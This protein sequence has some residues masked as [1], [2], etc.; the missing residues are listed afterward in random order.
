MQARSQAL[1]DH[2][3]RLKVTFTVISTETGTPFS[4]VG[5]YRHVRTAS[6]AAASRSGTD[7][8][9]RTPLTRPCSSMSASSSDFAF[10]LRAD[11]KRWIDG[12]G[13]H[14]SFRCADRAANLERLAIDWRVGRRR[15]LDL[16]LS[17]SRRIRHA[18]ADARWSFQCARRRDLRDGRHLRRKLRRRLCWRTAS[19]ECPRALQR[20]RAWCGRRYRHHPPTIGKEGCRRRHRDVRGER[21][22]EVGDGRDSV[23]C[24]GRRKQNPATTRA[25]RR[26]VRTKDIAQKFLRHRKAP[27]G[28]RSSDLDTSL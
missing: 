24:H 28:G 3:C 8:S 1:T 13:G 2:R 7:L 16:G 25:A 9:T 18:D 5:V 11:R 14:D 15:R 20:R 26:V 21:N 23:H 27:L 22:D 17:N 10:D 6:T 4:S 12:R 19:R